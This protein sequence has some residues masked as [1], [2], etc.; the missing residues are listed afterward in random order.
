MFVTRS[1]LLCGSALPGELLERAELGE[2]WESICVREVAGV[3]SKPRRPEEVTKLRVSNCHSTPLKSISSLETQ[4][5][6][7][8][9]I[10]T[11]IRAGLS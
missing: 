11:V 5:L 7:L 10:K 3:I 6:S 8:G 9:M 4:S 2:A 1:R